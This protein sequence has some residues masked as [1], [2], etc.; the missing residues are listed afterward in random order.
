[1]AKTTQ[2]IM[3][4]P[5]TPDQ[6]LGILLDPEFRAAN[7]RAMGHLSSTWREISRTPEKLVLET[8]VEEYAKGVTGIDRSKTERTQTTWEWD[9]VKRFASW[10]Y[11]GP[12]GQRV[13]VWGTIAIEPVPEGS[14][15]TEV[16]NVEI[17][18]PLVGGQIEKM[19]LREA[20]Q[21]WPR[22]EKLLG[23]YCAKVG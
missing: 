3:T 14:R 5:C 11:R 15:L 23:E 21:H 13:R 9:L 10:T 16:F 1:M 12:H 20:D 2:K 18:I 6:L 8:E 22:Y 4:F 19:V 17:K 7:Y